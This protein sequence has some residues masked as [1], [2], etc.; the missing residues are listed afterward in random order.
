MQLEQLCE[1]SED[2]SH[3]A[4]GFV[5]LSPHAIYYSKKGAGVV[6]IQTLKMSII[7]LGLKYGKLIRG[8][9]YD[10]VLSLR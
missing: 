8:R 3:Y 6:D 1:R 10:A 4:I 7:C 9:I 2:S 5:G